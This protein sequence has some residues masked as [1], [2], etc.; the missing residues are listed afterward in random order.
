MILH[1]QNFQTCG[2]VIKLLAR[3]ADGSPPILFTAGIRLMAEPCPINTVC[4]RARLGAPNRVFE[5]RRAAR[6]ALQRKAALQS[7]AA[8]NY[9]PRTGLHLDPHTLARQQLEAHVESTAATAVSSLR[10]AL[11]Q[12]SARHAAASQPPDGLREALSRD[13]AADEDEATAV[14]ATVWRQEARLSAGGLTRQAKRGWT[15]DGR[16]P[17]SSD[18]GFATLCGR[19]GLEAQARRQQAWVAG[20]ARPRRVLALANPTAHEGL[21]WW[22]AR[23]AAGMLWVAGRDNHT[24]IT[25][26]YSA[27]DVEDVLHG[28]I[29]PRGLGGDLASAMRPPEGSS[30]SPDWT[31]EG[32]GAALLAGCHAGTRTDA[33]TLLRDR[34]DGG[35][36]LELSREQARHG[37]VNMLLAR[38]LYNIGRCTREGGRF[39]RAA[40]G[41]RW[42]NARAVLSARAN[43]STPPAQEK[44]LRSSFA[45]AAAC[46]LQASLGPAPSLQLSVASNL[47]NLRHLERLRSDGTDDSRSP[48]STAVHPSYGAIRT[49]LRDAATLSIGIYVRTLASEIPGGSESCLACKCSPRRPPFPTGTHAR[50]RDPGRLRV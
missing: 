21:A 34:V 7:G 15:P 29:R 6:R 46:S 22:V 2:D 26:G 27:H 48:L 11:A 20:T 50:V 32:G 16:F 5:S 35:E 14:W 17:S 41:D 8:P 25:I 37:G 13:P 18:T 33:C 47:R 44:R 10:A 9:T 1:V 23:V 31:L 49:A 28:A 24:A 39:L 12:G 3:L 45:L 19:F 38:N 43:A 4:P 40:Y 42:D 36:N 30:A